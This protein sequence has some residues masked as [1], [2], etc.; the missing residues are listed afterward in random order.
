MPALSS[1][2]KLPCHND[3][4]RAQKNAPSRHRRVH[5]LLRFL[6]C[7]GTEGELLK[8][9]P[10]HLP[11]CIR[12][13]HQRKVISLA[14]PLSPRAVTYCITPPGSLLSNPKCR[15]HA[16][17]AF[18]RFSPFTYSTKRLAADRPPTIPGNPEG[19]LHRSPPDTPNRPSK[20]RCCVHTE[21][22][23]TAAHA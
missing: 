5:F 6:I 3:R 10:V 23:Q 19:A 21:P 2:Q 20:I 22:V 17:T 18:M 12:I 13:P 11:F 9:I 8:Y 15:C 1:K 4:P 7:S 16:S 14:K